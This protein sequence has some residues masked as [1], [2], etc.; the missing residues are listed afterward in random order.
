LILGTEFGSMAALRA[1]QGGLSGL[2]PTTIS[3]QEQY[4]RYLN[5]QGNSL[6]HTQSE[7]AATRG[8]K[9]LASCS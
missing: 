8:V 5:E 2:R 3:V 7:F 6:T 1:S 4:E 9:M